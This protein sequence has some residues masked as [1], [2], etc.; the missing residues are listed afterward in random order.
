MNDDGSQPRFRDYFFLGMGLAAAY[1]LGRNP[2]GCC[3]C[4][5]I[6]ALLAALAVVFAVMFVMVMLKFIIIAAVIFGIAL[7]GANWLAADLRR[8]REGR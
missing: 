8:R 5:V 3:C 6:L 1:N 7:V 2:G 4:L